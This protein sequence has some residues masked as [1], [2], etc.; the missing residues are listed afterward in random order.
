MGYSEYLRMLGGGGD[1]FSQLIAGMDA[2]QKQKQREE[3]GITTINSFEGIERLNIPHKYDFI[4]V[5][6]R[7]FSCFLNDTKTIYSKEGKFLFE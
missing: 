6:G 4:Q 5:G 3:E 7:Y 1:F 2:R